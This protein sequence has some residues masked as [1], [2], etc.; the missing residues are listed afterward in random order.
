[1]K[2]NVLT[3]IFCFY[4]DGFRAMTVGRKLGLIILI[5]LF[6]IFIILK[7]LFFPDFLKSRFKTNQERSDYVI[8]QLT[9]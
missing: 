1:M 3:R 9:K 5:K 2:K 7:L 4:Y 6:I 8:E